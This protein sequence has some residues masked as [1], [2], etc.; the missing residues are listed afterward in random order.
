MI[1]P[2]PV[3]LAYWKREGEARRDRMRKILE[4][5]DGIAPTSLFPSSSKARTARELGYIRVK[6]SLARSSAQHHPG[7][8]KGMIIK[9]E[10]WN[11]AYYISGR[12]KLVRFIYEVLIKP[13]KP[14]YRK[15]IRAFLRRYLNE[16]E[17]IAVLWRLGVR[18][19]APSQV[20]GSIQVDG[21]IKPTVSWKRRIIANGST[22]EKK[23]LGL[24]VRYCRI[25]KTERIISQGE[26]YFC[27]SCGS[28]AVDKIPEVTV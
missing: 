26:P 10:Y 14:M 2:T 22:R 28:Y 1:Q 9:S 12:T 25:C 23:L 8:L 19:I 18:K 20:K 27:L 5:H 11:R 21:I 7:Y 6:I 17:I 15:T 3:Q 24:N 16:A 13:I 4:E